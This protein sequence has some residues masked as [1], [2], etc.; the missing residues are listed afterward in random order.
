MKRL[1]LLSLGVASYANAELVNRQAQLGSDV[2]ADWPIFASDDTLKEIKAGNA[3]Q[4]S[5]VGSSRLYMLPSYLTVTPEDSGIIS[6]RPSVWNTIT[7]EG[8]PALNLHL[9]LTSYLDPL[10]VSKTRE[11][12]KAVPSGESGNQIY[13]SRGRTAKLLNPQYPLCHSTDVD[14]FV[15]MDLN[16]DLLKSSNGSSD[17]WITLSPVA[18]QRLRCSTVAL[19]KMNRFLI[20]I[21]KEELSSPLNM[22]I[23]DLKIDYKAYDADTFLDDDTWQKVPFSYTVRSYFT[24]TSTEKSANSTAVDIT[25]Q[26]EYLL[27]IL[28][29]SLQEA[30]CGYL[31]PSQKEIDWRTAKCEEYA[32]P[33][34]SM[35]RDFQEKHYEKK[36]SV[37]SKNDTFLKLSA[38]DSSSLGEFEKCMIPSGTEISYLYQADVGNHLMLNKPSVPS[39]CS[40][41]FKKAVSVSKSVY[42]YKPHASIHE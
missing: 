18:T 25:R 26:V 20:K 42:V 30:G 35:C 5:F 32:D 4:D 22:L 8:L 1:F 21:G 17:A 41:E 6:I 9:P 24:G 37:F 38:K 11:F 40:E 3:D 36:G 39:S 12:Y 14:C 29:G 33:I 28:P 7:G 31:E 10:H 13:V 2:S 23:G 19:D 27:S 34:R 15:K 16:E